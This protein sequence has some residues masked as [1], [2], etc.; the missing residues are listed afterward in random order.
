M[1]AGSRLFTN[2]VHS[3]WNYKASDQASFPSKVLPFICFYFKLQTQDH[4]QNFQL[5]GGNLVL[6]SDLRECLFHVDK[7]AEVNESINS[8]NLLYHIEMTVMSVEGMHSLAAEVADA[9]TC[10]R[11]MNERREEKRCAR[12]V[13]E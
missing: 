8:E 4:A 12:T 6:P 13:N 11:L 1:L 7:K 9:Y 3:G 5:S 10:E 2:E